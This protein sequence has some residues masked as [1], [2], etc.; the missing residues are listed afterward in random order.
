MEDIYINVPVALY[1]D[2]NTDDEIQIEE[3]IID[4]VGTVIFCGLV[5]YQI[6][7]TLFFYFRSS[8][9]KEINWLPKFI[10]ILACINGI[11]F[12]A[13]YIPTYFLKRK[14]SHDFLVVVNV[15][16]LITYPVILGLINRFQRVQVQLRA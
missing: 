9:I 14:T 15:I 1:N 8:K 7:M 11:S 13:Y 10:M 4:I 6:S 12:S 16:S 5:L 2:T 3:Y